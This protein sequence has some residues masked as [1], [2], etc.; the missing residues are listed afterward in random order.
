MMTGL[1]DSGAARANVV[2][3]VLGGRESLLLR[4]RVFCPS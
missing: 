3:H 1:V 4:L 2:A